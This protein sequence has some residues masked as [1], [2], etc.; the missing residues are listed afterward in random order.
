MTNFSLS[1]KG[2]VFMSESVAV[3]IAEWMIS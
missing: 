3:L 2:E 1:F